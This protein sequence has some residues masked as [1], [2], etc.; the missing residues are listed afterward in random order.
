MIFLL[1]VNLLVALAW[2]NHIHHEVA[3]SWFKEHQKK[4]WATC[5]VTQSG[6]IRVSSNRA[7]IPEARTPGEAAALLREIIQ[8]P[9]HSF[10]T[11]DISLVASPFV[12]MSK[13]H[14]FRQ[15]TDAHLLALAIRY[16]GCLA[17]L[18]RS[19]RALVPRGSDPDEVVVEVTR[20]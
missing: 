17:T 20:A 12:D 4:G 16:G 5:S 13:I 2:P 19:V 15:V 6:F 14:G 18:D 9:K 8:L 11:D 1:D 3:L 7:I 10:W